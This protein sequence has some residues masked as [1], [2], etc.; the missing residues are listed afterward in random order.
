MSGIETIGVIG[1]GQ[2]GNGIAHVAALAGFNVI[3]T[4]ISPTK[5]DEA[6]GL[7]RKNMTR[8]LNKGTITPVSYTHLDVYK[9]QTLMITRWSMRERLNLC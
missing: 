2:M 3:L 9:R 1:A 5:L 4:D 7:I 8:Q 6:L